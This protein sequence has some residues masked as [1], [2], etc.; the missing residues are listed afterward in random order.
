VEF[1]SAE[2]KDKVRKAFAVAEPGWPD[3]V[4]HSPD[5]MI[6][7]RSADAIA[8]GDFTWVLGEIHTGMNTLRYATWVALHPEPERMREANGHD[9]PRPPVQLAVTAEMG[10]TPT[11]TSNVLIGP[12]DIQLVFA[13][14]SSEYDPSR[15]MFVGDTDL[16]EVD[17]KLY[18]RRRGCEV[19]HPLADVF[20]D[21]LSFNMSQRFHL[22]PPAPHTPRISVD[23]VVVQRETWRFPARDLEF[24]AF[25]DERQRYLL[26]RRWM[27]EHGLPR[28]V[29]VRATGE[30]KPIY[31]DLTSLSSV[32]LLARSARLAASNGGEAGTVSVSEMLPDP[33]HLWLVD[34]EGRRYTSELRVCAVDRIGRAE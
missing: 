25:P 31:I 6:A 12:D 18:V 9:L 22:V 10:G 32:N 2:L 4:H 8:A 27:A 15:V 33:D 11:R 1:S 3:A 13:H 16:E 28:H 23:R 34:A 30:K 7:A 17:G 14:D 24:A 19:A 21:P 5:L 29:F 26:V 20:A